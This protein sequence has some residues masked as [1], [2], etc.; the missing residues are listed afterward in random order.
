MGGPASSIA[1]HSNA[2]KPL[3]ERVSA[4]AEAPQHRFQGA[5]GTSGGIGEFFIGLAMVVVG[6]YLFLQ[7][8]TVSTGFWILWGYNAFGL[9]LIPLL[10]GIGWLFFDGRSIIGWLLVVLGALIIF[11]GI[12]TNLQ[13]YFRPTSLFNTI[14]MLGLLAGGLGLVAR[15]LRPH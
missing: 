6:V 14:I 11:A 1:G 8:V 10:V 2:S 9:S 12:L 3:E 15:S 7:Q 4:T 5:G 13:V